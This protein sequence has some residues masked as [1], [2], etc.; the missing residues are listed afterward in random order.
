VI[1]LEPVND[2]A[3]LQFDGQIWLMVRELEPEWEIA[4]DDD[5]RG[6]ERHRHKDLAFEHLHTWFSLDH[7]EI[8]V[9]Y[10]RVKSWGPIA[11]LRE[12]RVF[13]NGVSK[14]RGGR[15]GIV[16]ASGS[17]CFPL[18]AP[19]K[20]HLLLFRDFPDREGLFPS[21]AISL[22]E[23]AEPVSV[24]KPLYDFRHSRGWDPVRFCD[25]MRLNFPS[26]M[27]TE[28]LP[29]SAFRGLLDRM[30]KEVEGL[31][32]DSKGLQ[33]VTERCVWREGDCLD[34]P[35]CSDLEEESKIR[36]WFAREIVRAVV[37]TFDAPDERGKIR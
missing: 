33:K 6:T 10:C 36:G 15:W 19:V 18:A 17:R 8:H 29:E 26:W 28:G 37:T 11:G 12:Y 13:A 24:P 21:G 14:G 25:L 35:T 22:W 9:D 32:L 27:L 1:E 5:R 20:S 4:P 34:R 2:R 7:R 3:M 30:A 16:C 23:L 31:I